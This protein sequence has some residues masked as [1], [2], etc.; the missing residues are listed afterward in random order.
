MLQCRRSRKAGWT[1]S[2]NRTRE[3]DV[4]GVDLWGGCVIHGFMKHI[5]VAMTLLAPVTAI[6]C[7]EVPDRSGEMAALVEAA[8]N[9]PND[10]AGQEIS[11][12]MWQIWAQA[13]DEQSQEI[14][15][16]GMSKRGSYDFLGAIAD[17]DTLIA[18]CP[19]YAEG[20]NQRAFTYF[21][22]G[23]F[24]QA[25]IDLDRA[26]ALRPDHVAARAGRALS[27]MNLGR[28]DEARVDLKAALDLNPWLPE[29]GLLLPGGPLAVKGEDI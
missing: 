11:D 6:A 13:P 10:M 2:P 12:R 29:R 7:A 20:Y 21:L 18:Y 5:L 26:L 14:L 17:F 24:E 19:D 15:D 25:L 23:R 1:K 27:L 22:N 4:C 3:R 16:S 8:R 9:A 28:L